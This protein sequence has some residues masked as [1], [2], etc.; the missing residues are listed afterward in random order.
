MKMKEALASMDALDDDQWTTDGAPKID[1]VSELVGEKI[2]RQDIVDAAPEFSKSNMVIPD[3]VDEEAEAAKLA[4]PEAEKLAEVEAQ[5]KKDAEEAEATK[6]A[7]EAEVEDE[8]VDLSLIEEYLEGDPLIERDFI[9]LL[10]EIPKNSLESLET[11]LSEQ[12]DEAGK[13]MSHAE[14]LKNRVKRSLAFTRSRMKAEMPDVSNQQAIQHFIK[15]Q[16]EARGAR[17]AKTKEVLK[18]VDLKTLDPRSA[19]DRA[20]ARKN[21]RGNARPTRQLMG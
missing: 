15:S 21:N 3:D 6:L 2:T 16:A 4:E 14:D 17:A 13:A 20:M 11:V 5:E 12:L 9:V 8:E 7:E 10:N 1:T 18:G 19:I